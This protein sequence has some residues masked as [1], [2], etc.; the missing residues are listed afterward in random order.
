[1]LGYGIIGMALGVAAILGQKEAQVILLLWITWPILRRLFLAIPKAI[2]SPRKKKEKEEAIE[3]EVVDVWEDNSHRRALPRT[4]RPELPNPN[5]VEVEWR[6]LPA[7][8]APR[9][10]QAVAAALFFLGS[11]IFLAGAL[12]LVLTLLR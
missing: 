4:T 7:P 9:W 1:M 10:K 3:A 5:V 12:S 6:E 2:E 8:S 11:L